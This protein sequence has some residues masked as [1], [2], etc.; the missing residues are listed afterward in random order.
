MKFSR[1]ARRARAR[2]RFGVRR[3]RRPTG[4]RATAAKPAAGAAAAEPSPR[5]AMSHAE[6]RTIFFGLM[7]AAFLAAL[8]QTIVAT[9]LPT[10]G[11]HFADFENL[12][13]VVTAYLLTSTAVAPLYGKLSDIHGRRAMILTSIGLF[14]AGSVM[15]AAAPDMLTL[16]LGRG[17]QGIGGGGILPLCQSVIADVVAPRERGRYQAYMGV[18]WVTAGIGGPVIGGVFAEHLHWS[19][20]FW[21][22]V[23]L[24]LGA[25]ALTHIHLKRIPRHER[26][27]KLDLFGA[28]LMMA[29]AIPLLLALTWGGTRYSW[30]SLPVLALVAVSFLLSAAFGLRLALAPEPFLPLTVLRNQVMRTGA[31]AGSLAMGVQIGL[32]IMVPLYFEVVHR[33]TASESGFALIPVA[34]TTPGSLLAGQAMLYWK[35]YKRAPIVGLWCAL[36]SL[37]FLVWRPDLPLIYVIVILSVLGTAI[38]LVFPT[39]TVAIQNA[40]PH[41]QVGIAMGALNFF[42]QLASAFVVAL[43][44]AV[45]LAGLGV[46]PERAGRAV[47]VIA[48]VSGSAGADVAFVFRWVFLCAWVILALALVAL[49]LMEERPLRGSV[50]PQDA[51]PR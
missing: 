5:A 18:V 26:P 4:E 37:A 15:C 22:N 47:S 14:M 23:P 34:L 28:G 35:H 51:P 30:L 48:T 41:Y 17:L 16:I 43:M 40:V 2:V 29:S 6:V 19:L 20:I 3:R 1:A 25:A 32:T 42:R 12:S 27:H 38:G 10:I 21:L 44:G 7:L 11:R 31:T 33:L 46:A 45:L 13:W 50:V 39:T 24:A 36:A 49:I 8:N 9:A